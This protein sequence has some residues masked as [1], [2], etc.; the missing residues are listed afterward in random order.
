MPSRISYKAP[1]GF[2]ATFSMLFY[3]CYR[4]CP[5]NFCLLWEMSVFPHILIQ[6]SWAIGLIRMVRRYRHRRRLCGR[7]GRCYPTFIIIS[8]SSSE[9][10]AEQS[11]ECSSHWMGW[12]PSWSGSTEACVR[13][14][15]WLRTGSCGRW[16]KSAIH[17]V[18]FKIVYR[19]KSKT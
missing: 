9:P 6:C 3:S 5:G 17:V 16:R 11:A 14:A 15:G 19:A 7:P 4:S 8:S 12:P 13:A 18:Q 2:S 10:V 1:R